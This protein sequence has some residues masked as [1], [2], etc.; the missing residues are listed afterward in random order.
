MPTTIKC[1]KCGNEIELSEALKRDL[2]EKVLQQTQAKHRQD[3]ERLEKAKEELIKTKDQELEEAKEKISKEARAEAIIKIRKAYDA[4]I[5]STKEDVLE[6]AKQNKELQEQ[7]KELLKQLRETRGEKDKLEIEYQKKLMAEEGKIK[8]K[9]RQEVEEEL[10]L[11]IAQKDKQLTDLEKQLKDAQRKAQ[12]GSQQLQGE[13]LELQLEEILRK[14]FIYDQIKE[15]PK[16]IKGADVIQIVR[17]NTGIVCGTILWELKN[18]KNWTKGWVTKLKEDQRL[19]KAE[20][21]ILVSKALP[22]TIK[23]FGIEN[24]VW[25][26]DINSAISLA[27]ALRRQLI[28][29]Q[30]INQANKGRSEKADV[31]YNYLISNEFK[32][33]IEVWVEY[34][35]NRRDEL[36]KERAYFMKKW[37]KEEKSIVKVV[38]N[39][40]GIYGDLQGLIGNALPKI[41]NL[42]LPEEIEN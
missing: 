39:T 22:E 13:V 2:E 37:E 6:Q 4:K 26:S 15:V 17:T 18:T 32:Q 33:R 21:A 34:F 16:G 35:K 3:I 8:Q 7:I 41:Q 11:K 29:I 12:Q 38:Q 31:V 28:K 30:S 24:G 40:A 19:L 1:N 14:E 25:I 9:A 36:E 10:N 23:T 42:E 20:L 5:E 27:H